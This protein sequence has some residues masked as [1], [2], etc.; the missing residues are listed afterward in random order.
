MF[1][2][3]RDAGMMPVHA[4]RMSC[5]TPARI[6][7]PAARVEFGRTI[8]HERRPQRSTQKRLCRPAAGTAETDPSH[9][10]AAQ[11]SRM[12][13]C[14]GRTQRQYRHDRHDSP[15]HRIA[16]RRRFDRRVGR[17]R[18]E[19]AALRSVARNRR[20]AKKIR[21]ARL[22]FHPRASDHASTVPG[23]LA[24]DSRRTFRQISSCG[25][26]RTPPGRPW[27]DRPDSVPFGP[28]D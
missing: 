14:R 3:M 6:E 27:P 19:P 13:D 24:G 8:P 12:P 15:S 11:G 23:R 7:M 21:G 4:S 10:R 22:N 5:G 28:A 26:V 1:E 20:P 9:G 2:G 17:P 18:T 25:T 16:G